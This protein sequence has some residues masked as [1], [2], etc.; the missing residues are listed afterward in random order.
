VEYVRVQGEAIPALGL[1]TWELTGSAC[2]R[3]VDEALGLGYR[4]IDTAQVYGNESEVGD[5]LAAS[6]VD[7]GEVFLTTKVWNRNLARGQVTASTRESL[8]K[9]RTDFVD[10]L[11]IHWPVA[12]DRIGEVLEEMRGL[13]EAG[14]VRH[15]GVSN[16]TVQQV[17][18]ALE[19]APILCDQVEY[20]PYL[21]QQPLLETARKHDLVLTAYSP[22]GRGALLRDPE[23]TEI[24]RAHGKSA[25]QVALR[26]LIDQENVA[27]I[28]KA[29]GRDHLSANIDVF[30]FKLSE[31]QRTRIDALDRR[32]RV[33]DPSFAPVWDR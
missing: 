10:L 9:L 17:E 4:H 29:T 32:D 18:E 1:G 12:M 8:S 3:A 20:H 22:L 23:L 33:I 27:A 24:G 13:Q 15:L 14:Q 25:A 26:W 16:F 11:L 28:P 6:D 2:R 7:R 31:D 30:D 19:H 21:G 5:A